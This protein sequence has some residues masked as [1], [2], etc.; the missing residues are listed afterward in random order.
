METKKDLRSIKSSMVTA[1][2]L[3]CI[4]EF[5]K[6]ELSAGEVYTFAVKLCD[7]EIDRDCERF[8]RQTL[9]QLAELFVGKCG[10]FDHEWSA[11]EQTARIY[12]TE[13]VETKE[14]T[15][16]GDAYC[17]LKGYAYMLRTEKNEE[18]IAEI[19]G[20]IKKEVSVGCSVRE[21]VCS[22][23]GKEIGLCGHEKGKVYDGKLCY[24]EL[25][26]ASDAYEWSFVAVPA[27]P[28]VGVMKR[29]G[30]EEAGSL[31]AL[32]KQRGSRANARE[33]EKLEQQAELGRTYLGELRKEVCRLMLTAEK[34]FDGETVEKM[35]E[36]LGEE[37]LKE[38]RRVYGEKSAKMLGTQLCYAGEMRKAEDESDFR[39]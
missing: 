28:K 11:K 29:Y 25:K 39:V 20:G 37:E 5:A 19:E 13:L 3:S 24:A 34:S 8:T 10:I 9:G 6:C 14:R 1:E 15:K 38:L 30:Q 17:Y 18:L 31:K 22:V 2:E 33:L 4:N 27:Q 32:V 36:K 12:R 21:S 7:N 26:D 35:T 16:A 23:C